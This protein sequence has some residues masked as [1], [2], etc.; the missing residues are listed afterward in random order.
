MK[1]SITS[2]RRECMEQGK[3]FHRLDG[4]RPYGKRS[5]RSR[6]GRRRWENMASISIKPILPIWNVQWKLWTACLIRWISTGFPWKRTGAWMRSIMES[7]KGWI[8]RK[9][10]GSMGRNKC[11]YGAAAMTLLL[12][13]LQRMTLEIHVS[14]I[15]ITRYPMLNCP[16]RI[17]EGYHWTYYALLGIKYISCIENCPYFTGGSSR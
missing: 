7:Y 16:Y 13:R 4:C 5:C 14:T 12:I 10:P 15:D 9:P 2:S 3:S 8:K 17:I 11:L 1:N 6:E